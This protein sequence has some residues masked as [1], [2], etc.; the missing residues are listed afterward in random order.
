M[1]ADVQPILLLHGL[2]GFVRL[3]GL[4]YFNGIVEDLLSHGVEAHTPR[5][6]PTASIAFRARQILDYIEEH[7]GREPVHLIGHSMGGLDARYLASP[8]GLNQGDRI[9]TVTTIGTPHQGSAIASLVLRTGM[10][11]TFVAKPLSDI[12]LKDTDDETRRFYEEVR[13]SR[14]EGLTELRPSSIKREF[15][16][17]I[18][19]HPAVRYFS[20]A[21]KMG[22]KGG[23]PIWL[24]LALQWAFLG[25][26]EGPNDGLVAVKSCTWGNFL[27]V[28]P[29]S[30][31]DL[32]GHL[33][34]RTGIP[35]DRFQFYRDLAHRLERVEKGEETDLTSPM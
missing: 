4:D 31:Q 21:G 7:F 16:P 35:F 34:P 32:I 26:V 28:L 17:R 19:D 14:W 6:H 11:R 2:A 8:N 25:M 5:V 30:H 9:L 15:N 24:P 1:C 18:L 27:G 20:F 23:A 13:D 22:G 3:F 29:A 12:A 10:N 33:S